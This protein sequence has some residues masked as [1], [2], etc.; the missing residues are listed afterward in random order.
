MSIY[1]SEYKSIYS[2]ALTVH[3]RVHHS[4]EKPYQ[5]DLCE[6]KSAYSSALIRHKRVH[7]GE[8][9]YQCDICGY[10]CT[11]SSNLNR[12][13]KIYAAVDASIYQVKPTTS[14]DIINLGIDNP[15]AIDVKL[16]D[17]INN[18]DIDNSAA[19]NIKMEDE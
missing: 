9:P 10:R 5:C 16:E 17:D 8:K 15:V 4:G 7:S 11:Q 19:V 13:K 3:K 12:H 14:W 1:T 2:S 6:Y 18:L